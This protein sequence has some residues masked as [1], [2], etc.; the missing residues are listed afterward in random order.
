VSIQSQNNPVRELLK[1]NSVRELLKYNPVRELLKYNFNSKTVLRLVRWWYVR[2]PSLSS[3]DK[4]PA[5][6]Q[7]E[8]R[9]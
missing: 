8:E 4:G 1:N 5:K 2:R 3:L 6:A 7:R 9:Y